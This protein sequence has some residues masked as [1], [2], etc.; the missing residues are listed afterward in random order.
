MR[1]LYKICIGLIVALGLLHVSFTSFNRFTMGAMMFLAAGLAIVFAGFLNFVLLR[2]VGRDRS[3]QTLVHS[4]NVVMAALFTSGVFMLPQPQVFF[5]SGLFVL[6]AVLA[7]IVSRR[8]G[9][10]A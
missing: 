4:S 9:T 6:T 10:R 5:G 8:T 1:T 7:F 2:D 3:I